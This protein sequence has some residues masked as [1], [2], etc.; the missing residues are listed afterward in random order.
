MNLVRIPGK[1]IAIKRIVLHSLIILSEARAKAG[2][3]T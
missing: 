1:K 3:E 2:S